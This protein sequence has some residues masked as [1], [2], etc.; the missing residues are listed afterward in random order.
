[1]SQTLVSSQ[2]ENKNCFLKQNIL[3]LASPHV[4]KQ[5]S[6]TFHPQNLAA[7]D[8]WSAIYISNERSHDISI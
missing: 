6:K 2:V 5:H 3:T 4:L 8:P 1:M 7:V